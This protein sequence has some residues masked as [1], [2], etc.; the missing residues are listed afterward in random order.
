MKSFPGDQ[1]GRD[2]FQLGPGHIAD[3]GLARK[4]LPPG[5]GFVIPHNQV[6]VAQIAG[7]AKA[8]HLAIDFAIETTAALQRGQKVTA[9]GTPP[10]SSL[11]ISLHIKIASG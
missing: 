8:Q 3:N 2:Y 5:E 4:L 1:L 10:T 9:T 7:D 6:A 11:A